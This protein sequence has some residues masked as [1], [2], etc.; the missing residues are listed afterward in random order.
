MDLIKQLIQNKQNKD[1]IETLVVD[2]LDEIIKYDF[3]N[4]YKKV[5]N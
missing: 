4:I 2:I 3:M 1:D 5:K